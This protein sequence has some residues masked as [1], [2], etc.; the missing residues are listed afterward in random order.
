M[1]MLL[2]AYQQTRDDPY[3][4]DSVGWAY[5]L[6]ELFICRKYLKNA[7]L[8]PDDPIVNDIMEMFFEVKYEI[9]GKLLLEAALLSEK[10][11]KS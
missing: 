5:F 2:N 3:I 6:T 7:L 10:Q 1:E 8:M 11:R 9:T 4:I